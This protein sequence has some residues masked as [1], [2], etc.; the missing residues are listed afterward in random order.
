MTQVIQQDSPTPQSLV[1]ENVHVVLVEPLYGGNI[2]SVARAMKNM[3]IGNLTLVNPKQFRNDECEWMAKGSA[4][5]LD[6]AR[7]CDTIDE[8]LA[9]FTVL[10]AASRRSGKFRRPDFTP[11]QMAQTLVPIS[12]GNRVGLVFGRE[13]SGLT[14]DEVTRCHYVVSIP[15]SDDMPSLN[16]AQSVLLVCYELYMATLNLPA[17]SVRQLARSETLEGFYDHLERVLHHLGFMVTDNPQHTM[18]LL[19]K[20]FSRADLDEKDVRLLRGVLARGGELHL[21]GREANAA[22]KGAGLRKRLA[23]RWRRGRAC[24][25][26]NEVSVCRRVWCSH[27]SSLR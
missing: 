11:R 4:D 15:T 7:V 23:R 26:K 8:A 18:N 12:Q 17:F 16:L 6:R 1:L 21:R 2:G 22:G 14:T 5:I 13:D 24:R 25:P 27:C 19:R 20:I 10:V 9:P 3:G